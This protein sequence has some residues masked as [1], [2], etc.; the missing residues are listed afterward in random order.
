MDENVNVPV[1]EKAVETP[2]E[3]NELFNTYGFD[4][5]AV[6]ADARANGNVEFAEEVEKQIAN[7]QA[8]YDIIAQKHTSTGGENI[9]NIDANELKTRL[10]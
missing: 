6:V 7:V 5:K 10:K 1:E 2:A 3:K 9:W 8:C 4:L